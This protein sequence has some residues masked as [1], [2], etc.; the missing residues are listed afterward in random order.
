MVSVFDSPVIRASSLASRSTSAFLMFSAMSTMV[1]QRWWK[2]VSGVARERASV[3]L[4]PRAGDGWRPDPQVRFLAALYGW[5]HP[6][7][8]NAERRWRS[9]ACIPGSQ[10]QQDHALRSVSAVGAAQ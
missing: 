4:A 9:I 1:D 10:G 7:L 2:G 8:Q 3:R 5:G 6:G